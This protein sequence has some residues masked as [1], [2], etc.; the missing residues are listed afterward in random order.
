MILLT[1][2]YVAGII[3]AATFAARIWAPNA[4]TFIISA[5]LRDRA[6]ASTWTLAARAFQRSHWPDILR[7]DQGLNRGVR[8]DILILSKLM[9]FMGVLIGIAGVVTPLGLYQALLPDKT[10]HPTFK[11]LADTSPYGYGTPPRSNFSFNRHCG[12]GDLFTGPMPCPFTDTVSI[13]TAY[14]NGTTNWNFPYG[15]DMAVPKIIIDTYS[16]GTDN[17]T[18]VSNFFDIQWRRYITT[19]TELYNNGTEYLTGAFRNIQ[20]L[21]MNNALEA[22][23]GLVVDTMKGGVGF[24]NHTVPPGFKHGVT[25]TEDLLFVEPETICVDTNLTLDFTI[26]SANNTVT[27][28]TVLTDR[29]G[30]VNLNHTYPRVDMSNPQEN[31]NL[32]DRA[33][34]AAW[35]QNAYTAL[36]FNITNPADEETGKHAFAYVNSEMNKTFTVQTSRSLQND[37]FDSL[38]I[39]GN[40]GSFLTNDGTVNSIANS[41]D[42]GGTNPFGISVDN[43]TTINLLCSGAGNHDFANS[44]N[45][46]VSCGNM[47]G[48]PQRVSPGSS[49]VFDRGSLWTQK[50][51]TCASAV[52][53][54]VKTVSFNYN[55]TQDL[56]KS[57]SVSS[58]KDKEYKDQTSMPLWGIEDTGNAFYT[59]D[60][61]LVWGIISSEYEQN[62]NVSALRSSSLY[63]PGWIDP[64]SMSILDLHDSDENLPASDFAV[65]A[66]GA[67]Y[68]VTSDGGSGCIGSSGQDYSGATNMAM[69][70]KW[71][72]LTRNAADASIIPN[73]IWTDVAAS[74]VVGTK[75]VLGPGNTA[76]NNLVAISVTPT[77]QKIRYHWPYA[78][79][80]LLV[81]F[82]LILITSLALIVTCFRGIGFQRMR[83]HL[84]Q[85]SPGRIYTNFL[86]P[87]QGIMTMRSREWGRTLG[88]KQID[89]S[90]EWPFPVENMTE[91]GK[92]MNVTSYE[93]SSNTHSTEGEILMTP[94][95]LRETSQGDVGYGFPQ[96]QQY[97]S[98]YRGIPQQPT[99][100]NATDHQY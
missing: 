88:R 17:T 7:T 76:Q 74:A 39:T 67:S 51:F 46:L 63:L 68:C 23:E 2:G 38:Q 99:S 70:A 73:L 86:Y 80:A 65:G 58:I 37:G 44:T 8:K 1:I 66:L 35:L 34:K 15:I 47:M 36:V 50:I 83:L 3:A 87:G 24:R 59:K 48:V 53:A 41:S 85:I 11:Y 92:G 60:I 25:W 81:A 30:F 45:I 93:R 64:S 43:F 12:E 31:P 82:M 6:S 27:G 4:L 40:F 21:V 20:N 33:Y 10:V 57:L 26:M 16:S 5:L 55:G 75:G 61:N 96:P 77:I 42:A 54:T 72:N 94:N 98:Q 28:G 29:G 19:S 95:D 89:L 78:I 71:Q 97:H 69:W 18:T 22:Y 79:P 90:G 32:Y 9:G 100:P 49:L 84:H 56:L 62:P 91:P 52:K 14:P 13:M